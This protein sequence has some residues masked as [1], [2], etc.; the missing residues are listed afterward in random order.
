[1]TIYYVNLKIMHQLL[2]TQ[3]DLGLDLTVTF[4]P[5]RPQV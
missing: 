4:E 1:M 3:E 5:I 2:H